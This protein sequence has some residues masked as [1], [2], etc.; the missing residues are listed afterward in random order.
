MSL[1][2][3]GQVAIWNATTLNKRISIT[4]AGKDIRFAWFLGE[5]KKIGVLSG[6]GIVTVFDSRTGESRWSAK[7]SGLITGKTVASSDGRWLATAVNEIEVDI[8]DMKAKGVIRTI[9]RHVYP[10][11]AL[12]FSDDGKWL[13]TGDESGEVWLWSLELTKQ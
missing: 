3:D 13:G 2:K 1:D 11:T 8:W 10:M 9:E 6:N 7:G 12:G 4:N 5:D